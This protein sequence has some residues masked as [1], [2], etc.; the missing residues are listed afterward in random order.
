LMM[1]KGNISPIVDRPIALVF[2]ALA[3]LF[4]GYK[5]VSFFFGKKSKLKIEEAGT[6]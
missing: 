2:L 5:L 1:F 3:G 4:V 6:L